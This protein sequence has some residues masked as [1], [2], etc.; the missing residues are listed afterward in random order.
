MSTS[1]HRWNSRRVLVGLACLGLGVAA[2]WQF[3]GG[4]ESSPDDFRRRC[5]DA[6]LARDWETLRAV[7]GRWT[8]RDP[9]NGEG[10]LFQAEALHRQGR[11]NESLSA[12]RSVPRSSPQAKEALIGQME[13]QFGPLNR[14]QGGADACEQLLEFDPKSPL[15]RQRLI[16]YLTM[17]L[18][19]PRLIQEIREAFRIE[20]E[21]PE[22]YV[23]LFLIDALAFGNGAELNGHWLEGSP[24][25]ELFEVAQAVFIAESLDASISLDDRETA[26]RAYR[27]LAKKWTIMDRLLET[28]PHNAELLAYHL[29]ECLLTG[30]V[31]RAVELLAQAPIEAE[32]DNRFWRFKGWVHA[33]WEELDDAEQA[34]RHALK[35]HPL[36]VGT[37]HLLADLLQ[38]RERR[39]EVRKLRDQVD[40]GNALRREIQS[41]PSAR[42]VPRD[43]LLRLADFAEE[44]GDEGLAR[45]IRRRSAGTRDPDLRTGR[46]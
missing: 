5:R 29:R 3:I 14:P 36:D 25:S 45:A 43:M 18:Q 44:C 26:L 27:G 28:F 15:G 46:R 4:G 17:T 16:F 21:P 40:R 6:R 9:S 32:E 38:R 37:R 12:L 41:A 30:K 39:D 1:L 10:W 7:S 34:Y 8:V 19:R 42:D 33:Q 22:A 20:A 11:V 23:Y 35:L 13:L 24:G 2:V 31:D